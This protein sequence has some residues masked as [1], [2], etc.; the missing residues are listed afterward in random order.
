[1]RIQM[2]P[3]DP[4]WPSKSKREGARIADVCGC[5]VG[6]IHHIGSTSIPGIFAEPIIDIVVEASDN[7][8]GR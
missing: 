7:V 5:S 6:A 4:D 3:P 1:M 8:H 2:V